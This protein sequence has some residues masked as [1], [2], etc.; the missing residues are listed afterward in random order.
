MEISSVAVVPTVT[1]PKFSGAGA[2]INCPAVIP[3]PVRGMFSPGPYT[4]RLPPVSPADC[5]AKVT[6]NPRLCPGLKVMGN[7]APP[8]ENSLP[9]VWMFDIVTFQVRVF[10]RTT[11]KVEWDPVAIGPNDSAEGLAV[12]TSLLAPVPP[13]S[14]T[15]L[16][17]EA[18]LEN[19]MVPPVHPVAV[20]VKLTLRST[21]WPASK[22]K[23]R[24]KEDVVN[25]ELLM[26]IPESVTLVGPLFVIVTSKLSVW[27]TSRT[28]NRRLEG[29]Q[30]SCG[31]VAPALVGAKPTS[32]SVALMVRK[33]TERT[34]REW[35]MDWGSR[36]PSS[37]KYLRG[38]M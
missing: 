29:E 17:F 20:G 2:M 12:T 6:L 19:L 30:L 27:P 15:R 7:V 14:T 31:A 18:L 26:A 21:L 25:S 38:G 35:M 36:M 16:G 22:V 13:A 4:N 5:G 32:R 34:E 24:A 33:W 3:V 8:T 1:F 11:G 9:V 10:V 28:P 23:G 37:L